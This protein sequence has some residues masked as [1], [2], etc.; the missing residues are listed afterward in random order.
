MASEKSCPPI[1]TSKPRERTA[2][3]T[4]SMVRV[5]IDDST[6]TAGMRRR[7]MNSAS[8]WTSAVPASLAVLI[9]WRPLTWKP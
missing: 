6:K 8:S 7:A 3:C 9:P 1:S 5:G 2:A 4:A